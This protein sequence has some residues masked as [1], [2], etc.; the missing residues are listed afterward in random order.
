MCSLHGLELLESFTLPP[1]VVKKRYD[2]IYQPIAI[3]E[4][5]VTLDEPLSIYEKDK[6]DLYHYLDILSQ[7]VIA[8]SLASNPKV[9][10]EV[11]WVQHNCFV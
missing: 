3:E 7:E 8:T 9:A 1:I 6:T 4:Y 5:V 10:H 11:S 2:I